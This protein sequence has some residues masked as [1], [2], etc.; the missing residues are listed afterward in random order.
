MK[1]IFPLNDSDGT[2]PTLAG[3]RDCLSKSARMLFA[4]GFD[5]LASITNVAERPSDCALMLMVAKTLLKFEIFK[6]WK[7]TRLAMLSY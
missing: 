2:I 7:L 3:M 6:K 5:S 4:A 1:E